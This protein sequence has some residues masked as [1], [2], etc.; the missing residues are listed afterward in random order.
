M[1]HNGQPALHSPGVIRQQILI[2]LQRRR[3]IRKG[4]PDIHDIQDIR[5]DLGLVHGASLEMPAV[6]KDLL[7]KLRRKDPRPVCEPSGRLRAVK[8]ET[9]EDQGLRIGQEVISKDMPF[10]T[11]GQKP[12]L[13]SQTLQDSV[14]KTV[15]PPETTESS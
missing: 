5:Q 10:K 11:A 8:E 1:A 2:A 14:G 3:T 4:L 6:G 12:R 13:K 15:Y 7:R 9:G